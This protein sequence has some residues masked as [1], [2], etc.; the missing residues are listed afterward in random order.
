MFASDNTQPKA[1]FGKQKELIGHL[2]R[3]PQH[4][5]YP[6]TY[7]LTILLQWKLSDYTPTFK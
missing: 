4:A 1:A 3:E 2:R 5:A 6:N 7:A